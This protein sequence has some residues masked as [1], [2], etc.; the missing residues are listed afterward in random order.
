[1]RWLH[2]LGFK[3]VRHRKGVYI[4]GHERDDVVLHR[5]KYLR[6]MAALRAWHRPPPACSDEEPRIQR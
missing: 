4:D 6:E 1:M 2:H 5:G 3:P